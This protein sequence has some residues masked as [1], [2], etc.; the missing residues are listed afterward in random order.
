MTNKRLP[1]DKTLVSELK[2]VLA[3]KD[4]RNRIITESI[5]AKV[6]Q[7]IGFKQGDATVTQT[8]PLILNDIRVMTYIH[9]WGPFLMRLEYDNMSVQ[10]VPCT[11]LFLLYGQLTS[12]EIHALNDEQLHISYVYA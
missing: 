2:I 11:G 6:S 5:A 12:V 3:D 8:Q 1:T 9:S 4:R 10:E 7:E